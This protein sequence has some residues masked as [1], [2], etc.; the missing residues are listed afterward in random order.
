MLAVVQRVSRAEVR[1][2]NKVVGKIGVGLLIYLAVEREDSDEELQYMQ[3]KL[4]TLRLFSG[5]DSASHFARN[6]KEVGGSV[7]LVSQFTLPGRTRKGT[8]PSFERAAG[9]EKAEKMI[10]ELADRLRSTE[11]EVETGAF[12]ASMVVESLN[13]GPVTLL[14]GSKASQAPWL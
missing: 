14:V 3:H 1:V 6:L 10:D 2:D 13:E 7:L 8:R 5:G 11:I 9:P 4:T 12:G